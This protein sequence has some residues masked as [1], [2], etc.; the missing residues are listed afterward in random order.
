MAKVIIPKEP[1]TIKPVVE[2]ISTSDTINSSVKLQSNLD[3]NLHYTGQISGKSYTWEGAGAIQ[4]VLAEDVPN[5]LEKKIGGG[6][7]CSGS[8]TPANLFTIVE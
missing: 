1:T 3:A 6:S 8:S 2:K 7:C 4:P 5:L